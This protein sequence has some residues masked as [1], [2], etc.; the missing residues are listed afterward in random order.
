MLDTYCTHCIHPLCMQPPATTKEVVTKIVEVLPRDAMMVPR[1]ARMFVR[2]A[3]LSGALA[4]G[5]GAYGA[6]GEDILL[7]ATNKRVY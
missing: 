7:A 6:H 1:S 4:V 3:G 5:M 2:L